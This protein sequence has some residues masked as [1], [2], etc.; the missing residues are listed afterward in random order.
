MT[1]IP[2]GERLPASDDRYRPLTDQELADILKG[3]PR[4]PLMAGEADIRL[5]LAG[6]QDKIAVHLSDGQ[7]ALP[8]DGAPSTH[9]LKPAIERFD[10]TVFNEAFSMRL[11]RAAGLQTA[12]VELGEAGGIAYLLVERYDRVT[13]TSPSEEVEN[14]V[15]VS[16]LQRLHQED[17]CQAFGIVSERKYQSEGGPSLK[18]C[19]DLVREASS[20]PALDLQSLLDAVTFNFLIGNNDAHGKNFSLLYRGETR[21]NMETRL[22]PFYDLLSTAYYPELNTKMAMKIGGEYDSDKVSLKHFEGL[23]EEVGLGKPIVKR[24]VRELAETLLAKITEVS[25]EHPVVT[26][27]ADLVRKRCERT[28]LRR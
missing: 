22:A 24:R 27:V 11:A 18:Q 5:S 4:R 23:A 9:V 7:I 14:H 25:L 12:K 13:R 6:A 19:F 2:S 28:A 8:L 17:F 21:S 20:V 3:L 26:G 1:F 10:G 15:G 16:T